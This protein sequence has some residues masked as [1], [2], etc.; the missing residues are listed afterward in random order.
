[1]VLPAFLIYLPILLICFLECHIYTI[2]VFMTRPEQQTIILDTVETYNKLY[3]LVTHHPLVAVIDLKEATQQLINNAS[4]QYGLYAVYLKNNK[5]CQIRYGHRE[6]DYEE[7]AVVTFAPGTH[8]EVNYTET[9]LSPDVVGLLFHPD[10]IYGTSLG[11]KINQFGFFQYSQQEALH[12]SE[13]EREM[14]NECLN[15]IRKEVEHPIDSHS[16]DLIS[17]NILLLLE[18]LNRFY[19]RQFI[20]R[21]RINTGIVADFERNLQDYFA[22]GQCKDGVPTVAYFAGRAS[23]TP[24]YFGDLVKRELGITAQDVI[25]HHIIRIAKQR[26]AATNDDISIIAY[27]L[28]F[29]YPQHFTRLFKNVAGQSPSQYRKSVKK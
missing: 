22:S 4:W 20:T 5:A 10:L 21:H 12:L 17:A 8:V 27:N 26:L 23:L 24:G 25:S 3:G 29:Q 7:G 1:M 19:D 18:Y 9:E 28:G 6:C 13:S 15:R 14:F 2:F 11:D 16:A